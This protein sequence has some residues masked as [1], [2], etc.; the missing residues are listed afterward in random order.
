MS[1]KTIERKKQQVEELKE[2]MQEANSVVLF[3]Y[4][5]LSVEQANALRAKLRENNAEMKVIKNNIIYRAAQAAGYESLVEYV[6][7]PNAVAFSYEDSVSAAKAIYDFSKEIGAL[8]MKVGIVD[9][10][11]MNNEKINH[12]ATIPS[13]EELLTMFAGGIIEPIRNIAI[14]LNMHVE[15]LEENNG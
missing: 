15:N 8:E 11:F 9:D 5:G 12:I 4:L 13:R 2:R 6:E 1:E 7:G 10:E 14:A 3:D